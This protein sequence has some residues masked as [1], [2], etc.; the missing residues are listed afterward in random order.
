MNVM[1]PAGLRAKTMHPG[2]KAVLR[3][4]VRDDLVRD[5]TLAEIFAATA[6]A[7]PDKPALIFGAERLSYREVESRAGAIAA[8]LV[9]RGVGPGDVVGLWMR[10]GAELLI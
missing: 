8:G 9:A 10:R 4:D 5:E 2:E 7:H 1:G 3:G 6:L